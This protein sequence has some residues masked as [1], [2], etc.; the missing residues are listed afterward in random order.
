MKSNKAYLFSLVFLFVSLI[1]SAFIVEHQNAPQPNLTTIH[2]GEG[3]PQYKTSKMTFF[4]KKKA[5]KRLKK[6]KNGSTPHDLDLAVHD[7]K[8]FAKASW[9]CILGWFPLAY[10]MP[11]L[12]LIAIICAPI[13]AGFAIYRA[14]SVIKDP[15]VSA[16]QEQKARGARGDGYCGLIVGLIVVVAVGLFLRSFS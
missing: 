15:N 1:N 8:L 7:A 12:G 2:N 4:D 16:V 9:G 5:F 14:T 3:T 10:L 13:F 11:L 6:L